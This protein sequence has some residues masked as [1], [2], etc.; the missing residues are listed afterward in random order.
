[1]LPPPPHLLKI[2][3]K[4]IACWAY[5]RNWHSFTNDNWAL[6]VKHPNIINDNIV[7]YGMTTSRFMLNIKV[8]NDNW[9][10]YVKQPSITNNNI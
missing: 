3:K 10:L 1:M 8:T 6:Y 2:D 5:N 9:T 4:Y 7:H